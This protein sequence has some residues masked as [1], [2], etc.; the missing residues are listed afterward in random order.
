MASIQSVKHNFSINAS[1]PVYSNK[2]GGLVSWIFIIPHNMQT[3][4]D[5]INFPV[6][7]TGKALKEVS[8]KVPY[9]ILRNLPFILFSGSKQY[10]CIFK[11]PKI[12][13]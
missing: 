2:I 5:N 4:L 10:I 9:I 8:K 3:F 6:N 11:T 1:F 12:H 13:S 7:F